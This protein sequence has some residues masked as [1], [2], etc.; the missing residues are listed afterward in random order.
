MKTNKIVF[1][2]TVPKPN[3]SFHRTCAKN[4]AGPVNSDVIESNA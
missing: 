2:A 4:R 1:A 3:P